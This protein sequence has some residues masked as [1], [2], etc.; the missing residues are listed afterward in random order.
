MALR[1]NLLKHG[2]EQHSYL[3]KPQGPQ[4]NF[5]LGA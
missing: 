1:A 4:Y 5:I 3:Y 2:I